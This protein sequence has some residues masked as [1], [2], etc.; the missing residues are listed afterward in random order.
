MDR[1]VTGR[2]KIFC[3]SIPGLAVTLRMWRCKFLDLDLCR[4]KTHFEAAHGLKRKLGEI[5]DD[6]S[7]DKQRAHAEQTVSKL[8][9]QLLEGS[10]AGEQ[11]ITLYVVLRGPNPTLRTGST[12]SIN[13]HQNNNNSRIPIDTKRTQFNTKCQI[14]SELEISKKRKEGDSSRSY[15][16]GPHIE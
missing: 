14:K 6:S 2:T 7:F 12:G 4:H 10:A 1:K 3:R 15:T 5:V 13:N 9:P 16:G 8:C 11:D